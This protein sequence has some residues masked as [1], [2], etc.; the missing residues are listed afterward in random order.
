M[1]IFPVEFV[2]SAREIVAFADEQ[3]STPLSREK[4]AQPTTLSVAFGVVVP[5][6]TLPSARTWR[7][8]TLAERK[9]AIALVVVVFAIFT[10]RPKFQEFVPSIQAA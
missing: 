10:P 9:S 5:I 3:H 1:D 8:E 7:R 6:P 2:F 4:F